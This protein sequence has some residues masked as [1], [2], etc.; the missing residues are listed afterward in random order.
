MN[1]N[2]TKKKLFRKYDDGSLKKTKNK[3]KKRTLALHWFGLVCQCGGDGNATTKLAIINRK[4]TF[5]FNLI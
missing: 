1:K 4:N 2:K 3:N 5:Y